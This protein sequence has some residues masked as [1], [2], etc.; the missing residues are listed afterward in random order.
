MNLIIFT[1]LDGSLLDSEDYSFEDAKQALDLLHQKNIPLILCTSKTRVEV[2]QIRKNLGIRHPFIV[3]NGGG[4]FF[5]SDQDFKIE[6]ARKTGDFFVIQLGESYSVIRSFVEKNKTRFSI[7]GFG[8]WPVGRICE[9][10]GLS[11]EEA[12]LAREREFT[13]PFLLKN[14][15]DL[16]ALEKEA[17]RANLK[18]AQGGRFFHL[19]GKEQDKGRAVEM[20]KRIYK[21]NSGN[22]FSIGLGDSGNDRSMLQ[23]VDIPVLIPH[24]EGNFISFTHPQLV[25]AR[26][27]GS[28]GWNE[29]LL[30]VLNGLNII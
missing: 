27:P 16:P 26:Y 2:E 30:R 25:K 23:A 19:I 22:I 1:D 21:K 29:A 24:P 12:A 20:V 14:E 7:E 5:E 3:E 13:E 4:I 9:L 15:N 28:K 10:T 6:G 18:I 17:N 11:R 8:D